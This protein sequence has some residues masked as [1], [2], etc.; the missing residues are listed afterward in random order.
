MS[1]HD[2][3]KT[4]RICA[5][6]LSRDSNAACTAPIRAGDDVK[7][8]VL[9]KNGDNIVDADDI[10]KVSMSIFDIGEVNA[11][12][13]R[14]VSALLFSESGA[15]A[16]TDP[17]SGE[18]LGHATF[19]I[20]GN[21]S[22]AI[23][24]DKAWMEICAFDINGARTTF[25]GSWIDV[26][27]N[28]GDANVPPELPDP[29]ENYMK[30]S[31][32]EAVFAKK[33][34]NL[35]DMSDIGLARENISV[36]SKSEADSLLLAKAENIDFSRLTNDKSVSGAINELAS[37]I[38]LKASSESLENLSQEISSTIDEHEG[39]IS[40]LKCRAESSG[41]FYFRRNGV[42]TK[43]FALREPFTLCATVGS[44][45]SGKILSKGNLSLS[46]N[47]NRYAILSCGSEIM[48][49]SPLGARSAALSVSASNGSIKLYDGPNLIIDFPEA[50]FAD[51]PGSGLAIASESSIGTL[52]RIKVFNFAFGESEMPYGAEEYASGFNE[53]G[54][55]RCGRN[56]FES[57]A[58]LTAINYLTAV[59]FSG[60]STSI[61]MDNSG[62]TSTRYGLCSL[63][64]PYAIRAGSRI[65]FEGLPV[66]VAWINLVE[67]PSIN[68]S[69]SGIRL[70]SY[71]DTKNSS[72]CGKDYS[73][74]L[75]K[76]TTVP[77]GESKTSI[78]QDCRL[79]INGTLL[80]LSD[81][82]NVIQIRDISGN[83]RHANVPGMV[84]ADKMANPA[85]LSETISWA[86]T[87]TTQQFCGDAALAFSENSISSVYAISDSSG[88]FDFQCGENTYQN[89]TLEA[90]N[91]VK[92]AEGVYFDESQALYVTP[93][94]SAAY[95]GNVEIILIENIIK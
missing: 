38:S 59:S 15:N 84:F 48:S 86:G 51:N 20:S 78:L 12:E 33:S 46:I 95:T 8:S 90:G 44:D 64:L 41:N 37:E 75:I 54:Y 50:N 25:M 93:S 67:T 22:S 26:L 18:V 23:K 13:P 89:V 79:K 77:A 81:T 47:S 39:D 16:E 17:E 42:V 52:G 45:F 56:P 24:C 63:T 28:R 71:P 32:A 83:G 72:I 76:T 69:Q 80:S 60:N 70:Y 57:G 19:E 88:A 55:M 5:D 91:M 2:I 4:I 31:Q 62:G 61:L 49:E 53:P 30:L 14:S 92:V 85:I 3:R 6:S 82:V 21:Q 7:I 43:A 68:E 73:A 87:Y 34:E 11:P 94:Q 35:A 29:S 36:Y 65:E 58:E 9:L 10:S 74:L 27:Q 40:S 66:N 1:N